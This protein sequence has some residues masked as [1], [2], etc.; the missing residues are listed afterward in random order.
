VPTTHSPERLA[1]VVP[2]EAD[3][4]GAGIKAVWNALLRRWL[5]I[6]LATLVV[7]ALAVAATM[8]IEPRYQA[9]ARLRVEPT[10][11]MLVGQTPSGSNLPDQSIVETEASIMASHDHAVE[12]VRRLNLLNDPELTEGLNDLPQQQAQTQQDQRIDQVAAELGKR[13]D[14]SRRESTYVVELAVTSRDPVKAAQIANAYVDVYIEQSVSRRTGTAAGQAVM[15]ERRLEELA[16]KAQNADQRLAQFRA[17]NGIA[18]EGALSVADQQI[19]PL[20]GQLATAQSEAAAARARLAAAQSQTAAGGLTA[21]SAVLGSPVIANLRAQRAALTTQ[22]EEI[23][24][25]F[26][27][28]HPESIR[29]QEQLR[30]VDDQI[31]EEANRVVGS[32]RSEAAAASARAASLEGDLNA[33]R[34]SRATQTQASGT[35]ATLIRAAEAAQ[36]AYN[37]AA[38]LAQRTNQ[39]AA[40]PLSQAQLI[41]A[42]TPPSEPNSPN[43]RLL[44]AGGLVLGL[45]LGVVLAAL[46]ELLASGARSRRDLE[47]IGLPLLASVPLQRRRKKGRTPADSMVDAPFTAYAEAFRSMRNTLTISSGKPLQVVALVSSLPAEGKTTTSLS[48]ARMMA[49][50]GERTLIIDADPRGAGLLR[51]LP[52]EPE[53]G[54]VEVL[55]EGV[56]WQSAIQPDVVEGLDILP[57][58]SSEFVQSDVFSKDRLEALLVELRGRYDRIVFDTPP[59]LGVADARVIA[60]VADA[61]LMVVRWDKT[62]RNAIRSTLE[63]LIQ[64]SAVV[65]G[66]VFTMVDPRSEAAG[67]AH[68]SAYYS[69]YLQPA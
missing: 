29:I 10:Q 34:A 55:D 5:T 39:I 24:A 69:S 56:A 54:L 17:A 23:S 37:Q 32:L 47:R 45:L 58:S 53:V 4:L 40:S 3:G 21:V 52:S 16:A 15:I 12:V 13:L 41:E 36:L 19:A 31:R 44:L 51:L 14:V 68:Y 18:G 59:V 8:L 67:G 43:K 49:M 26:G 9:V 2:S 25:T 65:I 11:N 35:E 61:V 28:R 66:A 7:V 63:T 20:A 60:S 62:P 33:L 42:A 27:P 46:Q 1:P 48:L 6:L 30:A 50:S 38:E 64:D 22:F 57:V